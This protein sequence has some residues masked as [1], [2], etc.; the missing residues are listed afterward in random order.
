MS[1]TQNIILQI[2]I[3]VLAT[4]STIAATYLLCKSRGKPGTL[5]GVFT[6]AYYGEVAHSFLHNYTVIDIDGLDVSRSSNATK[7]LLYEG[8]TNQRLSDT[9]E[10]VDIESRILVSLL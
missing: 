8:V 3:I 6:V 7:M 5:P 1:W 2:V 4:Y 9:L 10:M